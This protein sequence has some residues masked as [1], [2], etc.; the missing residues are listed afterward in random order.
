MKLAL[1]LRTLIAACAFAAAAH[2]GAA[3]VLV[4]NNGILTGAKG[5]NVGGKLYDLTFANGSCGSLFS[6][7]NASAFAFTTKEATGLAAQALLDQVFVDGAAGQ[8]DSQPS[9]TF[10]C[11]LTSYCGTFIPYAA[12][13]SSFDNYLIINVAG[14]DSANAGNH[15]LA[16]NATVASG[17]NFAVFNASASAVPEP[18]SLSLL[19]LALVGLGLARRRKV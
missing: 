2:A 7:C 6:A 8:F 5:V 3:P 14:A 16:V 18:G 15:S 9:K 4:V 1:S 11:T 10:G 13:A 19:G 17:F 12:N